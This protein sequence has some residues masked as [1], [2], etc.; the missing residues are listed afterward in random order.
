MTKKSIKRTD[1]VTERHDIEEDTVATQNLKSFSQEKKDELV[2]W[3]TQTS[4]GK[5]YAKL[6]EK[7]KDEPEQQRYM[8]ENIRVIADGKIEMV[9]MNKIISIVHLSK[10]R[11]ELE[12]VYKWLFDSKEEADK[13][14]FSFPGK[15]TKEK[16]LNFFELFG[17]TVSK[18][19]NPNTG[20]DV[21]LKRVGLVKPTVQ[22]NIYGVYVEG[23]DNPEAEM[24]WAIK[25]QHSSVF[26][27]C[28]NC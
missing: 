7:F 3:L 4:I 28:E 11:K 10:E 25:R 2:Q 20:W 27:A 5:A 14:I 1:N 16:I 22:D 24:E 15:N 6:L 12:I 23:Y 19:Y 17:L 21:W 9:K 26:V 18:H 8:E 13:F